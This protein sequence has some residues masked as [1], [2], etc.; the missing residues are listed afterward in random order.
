MFFMIFASSAYSDAK[1][2]RAL[3]LTVLAALVRQ[4]E[5]KV[6]SHVDL[7]FLDQTVFQLQN[8]DVRLW[9]VDGREHLLCL[10]LIANGHSEI[11][12]SVILGAAALV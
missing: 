9:D 4:D 6:A 2:K 8:R 11:V 12:K 10:G 7:L 5:L 3:L 1:A